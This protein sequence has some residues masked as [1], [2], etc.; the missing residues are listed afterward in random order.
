MKDLRNL[1]EEFMSFE[2]G[3]NP[4]KG[5]KKYHLKNWVLWW[6]WFSQWGE[7]LSHQPHGHDELIRSRRSRF[8]ET[9]K[10][11]ACS[12]GKVKLLVWVEQSLVAL[13][14]HFLHKNRLSFLCH[15]GKDIGWQVGYWHYVTKCSHLMALGHK[16]I[17]RLHFFKL[18]C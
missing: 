18:P 11:G 14:P 1:A 10:D 16:P 5:I 13:W 2:G 12:Q 8:G 7:N 4:S 17:P 9:K 15:C 3:G 6:T